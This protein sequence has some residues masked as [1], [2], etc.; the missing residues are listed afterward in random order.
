M[1]NMEDENKIDWLNPG[2]IMFFIMAAVSDFLFLGLIAILIP[3]IGLAIA[4]FILGAHY[5][6]GIIILAFSWGRT[7][8]WMPKMFLI[9]AWVIPLPLLSMGVV[10]AIASSN[11]F[12]AIVIEQAAIQVVAV[13]TEGA[14]EALEAGAV[15]AEGV[16]LA[17]TAAESAEAVEAAGAAAEGA[18]TAGGVATESGTQSAEAAAEGAENAEEV[19]TLEPKEEKNPIENLGEDLDNPPEDNF[20]EGSEGDEE[21]AEAEESEQES[22]REKAKKQVKKVIDIADSTN[23]Q[24]DEEE[25]DENQEGQP[26]D[27]VVNIADYQK[28]RAQREQDDDSQSYKKVA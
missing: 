25:E 17:A 24:E 20:S 15:A 11:K 8:G 12:V 14:G 28:R 2:T 9:L 13:A 22:R 1:P 19:D 26:Q 18:G 23:K 10:L 7:R 6:F 5:L 3:G 21:E 16:E 27:N 4:L